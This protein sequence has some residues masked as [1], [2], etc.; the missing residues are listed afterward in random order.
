[1]MN[2]E[3]DV[4]SAKDKATMMRPAS[5]ASPFYGF[6][7]FVD[8]E[9]GTVFHSGS[10]PGIETLATMVPAEKKGVVVL[11]NAGSGIGF[12]ETM[13]LRNGIAARALGLDYAGEGSR[14][15]QKAVF[16]ALALLPFVFLSS[17]VWA[18]FHRDALR[19]KSGPFGLFSLWFPLLTT[20]GIAW[21]FFYLIPRLF[22]L[23][24]G[25]LRVFQP[26]LALTMVATAAT[27]VMWAV[28][29]LGVAYSGA[30]RA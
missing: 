7:W 19:A 16:I 3:D 28:F 24:I 26:D 6:G 13:D 29:R 8:T 27:G 18:W 4:I 10:S 15:Q 9:K 22:G 17:M 23:S 20:L 2:G 30:N 5:A 14:W 21:T 25:T 1:M 11:V 12:G